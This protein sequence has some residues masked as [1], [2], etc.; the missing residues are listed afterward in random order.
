MLF[1][2]EA[3]AEYA[4]ELEQ[5]KDEVLRCDDGSADQ[6]AGCMRLRNSRTARE[7]IALCDLRKHAET[8]EKAGAAVPSTTYFAVRGSDGRLVGV[9]DLRHH[10]DHPV[11]GTWG[12]RVFR[13]TVRAW[14]G[15]CEGDAPPEYPERRRARDRKAP[16]DLR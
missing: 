6:F 1:L 11:L 2:T 3:N 9:I 7:W 10:I 12:G 16:S 15:L 14:E 4:E 5:F 8:C 13:K